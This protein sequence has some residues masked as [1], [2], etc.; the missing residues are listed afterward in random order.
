MFNK[1]VF[2]G[3]AYSTGLQFFEVRSTIDQRANHQPRHG[4]RTAER[5]WRV[6]RT[7]TNVSDR[8]RIYKS[9]Y[10]ISYTNRIL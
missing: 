1:K 8:D 5:A 6:K 7:V 10:N 4:V 9:S 2:T 3:I